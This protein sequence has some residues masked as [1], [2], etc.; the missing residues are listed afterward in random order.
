LSSDSISLI[1]QL[2]QRVGPELGFHHDVQVANRP[3]SDAQRFPSYITGEPDQVLSSRA[4]ED[5]P[6]PDQIFF[7][8]LRAFRGEFRVLTIHPDWT[9]STERPI[10]LLITAFDGIVT[11]FA[12]A[13]AVPHATQQLLGAA[14][15]VLRPVKLLF[16]GLVVRVADFIPA[17]R[18]P[19][20]QQNSEQNL[21]HIEPPSYWFAATRLV[22]SSFQP[23]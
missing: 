19:G 7:S 20:R 6:I 22:M 1:R 2:R 15:G 5:D 21:A 9:D 8:D 16:D 4:K 11:G 10:R 18:D 17:R 14:A 12:G 3:A 23:L 13:A